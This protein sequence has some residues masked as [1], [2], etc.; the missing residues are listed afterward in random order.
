MSYPG[1]RN[2]PARIELNHLNHAYEN[3][4]C[5]ANDEYWLAM[6]PMLKK[7][8]VVTKSDDEEKRIAEA[9][10]KEEEARKAKED[11]EKRL[12]EEEKLTIEPFDK[13]EF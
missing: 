5:F 2:H 3:V 6:F 9:K 10:K 7:E 11:E 1:S 4:K 8:N 13:P 12:A